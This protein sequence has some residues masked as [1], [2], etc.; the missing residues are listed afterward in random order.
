MPTQTLTATNNATQLKSESSNTSNLADS[1]IENANILE[2]KTSQLDNQT[3]TPLTQ[4]KTQSISQATNWQDCCKKVKTFYGRLK[5]EHNSEALIVHCMD[6]RFQEAFHEYA[7]DPCR[8]CGYDNVSL[9]GGVKDKND[10]LRHVDIAVSLH[11][12]K[13]IYLCNHENCGAYPDFNSEDEEKISHFSDLTKTAKLIQDKYPD[14]TIKTL[15]AEIHDIDKAVDE[16]HSA[17]ILEEIDWVELQKI[18]AF[19]ELP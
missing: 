2:Y 11:N 18:Q 9:A 14:L 19:L 15:Y 10:V 1:I 8:N 17:I 6:H 12:I 7:S 5:S 16:E 3:L 13:K 4:V